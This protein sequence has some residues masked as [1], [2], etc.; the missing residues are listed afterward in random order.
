MRLRPQLSNTP[1]P[2]IPLRTQ[3]PAA[4]GSLSMTTKR[5]GALARVL[6]WAVSLGEFSHG[7]AGDVHAVCVR[8]CEQALCQPGSVDVMQPCRDPWVTGL[9]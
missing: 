8:R 4:A 5:A 9:C 7:R 6:G 3:L 2:S 1:T